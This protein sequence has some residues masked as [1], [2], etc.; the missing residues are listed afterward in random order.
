VIRRTA[1]ELQV[2]DVFYRE[3]Y[4]KPNPATDSRY[5]VRRL[6]RVP[7]HDFFGHLSERIEVTAESHI[8]GPANL[9]LGVD[10]P[11]WLVDG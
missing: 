2:G 8:T 5:T 6:Q 1:S 11:V 10:E 7:V 3:T 4:R 9:S